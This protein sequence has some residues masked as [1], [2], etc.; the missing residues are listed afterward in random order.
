MLD[1]ATFQKILQ[2]SKLYNYYQL[3]GGT[4]G[5]E[6]DTYSYYEFGRNYPALVTV[7]ASG[8]SA[9]QGFL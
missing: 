9:I 8:S 3:E 6:T 2:M 7:L 5:M 1:R 4:G